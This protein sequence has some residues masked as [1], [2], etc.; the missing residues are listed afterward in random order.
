[1][2]ASTLKPHASKC[3]DDA[4]RLNAVMLQ[5]SGR[6]GEADSSECT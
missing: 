3:K 5:S 1:M 6:T 2:V 4:D